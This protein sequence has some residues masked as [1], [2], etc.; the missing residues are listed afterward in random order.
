[1][2][3]LR[4][5]YLFVL[6]FI[7]GV[8][9]TETADK[10][11]VLTDARKK[12]L[13]E[14]YSKSDVLIVHQK[15]AE[16]RKK[17]MEKLKSKEAAGN[18]PLRRRLNS[19]MPEMLP[20]GNGPTVLPIHEINRDAN[21]SEFLYQADMVLTITQAEQLGNDNEGA[22]AKRQA[23]RDIFYPNTIWGRT[24]F[25]FFD[26]TAPTDVKAAFSAAAQFW[27][28]NTCIKF[29]EDSTALNRIRVFKGDGCYSYV[30]KVGGQQDLSLGK[31]CESVGTAAHELGHALGF[32]H[33]QSRVDRDSA[34][35][36][37]VDNIQP[38]FVDQF[39][40]ESPATN[41]NYG[42]PYDFGS[43]MQYG[44]T[45]ASRN[46][47]ETMVSK[48]E[49]YQET[50]GSDIVG[51]YDVSMM[52]EHYNCKVLCP[53]GSSA[54]CQNGG[55][56]N[57]NNCSICN[58]PS[59]YGGNLCNE[60]PDGCGESLKA[61]PD[62]TQLVSSIGDGTTRTNI[63]FAKCIYWIQAP[64]GTRVEV[65]IDSLQGYT[66]DGCIYGGVEIKAHADQLRTGYRFCSRSSIGKT[67]IGASNL[68]PVITFNRYGRTTSGL[69]YRYV[70][71]VA[72]SPSKPL[73]RCINYFYDCNVLA[74]FGYCQSDS[75][76]QRCRRACNDC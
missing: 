62:Y 37:I 36:I 10:F 26:P 68:L 70:T 46:G 1:M 52:N 17:W 72:P 61:G 67:L 30:G 22:R 29:V 31:G 43:I 73:V 69:S 66:I 8:G 38:S 3:I 54:Q 33:S 42:M 20:Q 50:M 75:V 5:Y 6:L 2:L 23:Y 48:D 18:Q 40:K 19:L 76:R 57:P 14:A 4:N 53:R 7:N 34:I 44:A 71:T 25:Y 55:Y 60:R 51:F 9:T 41:Y 28:S 11:S 16:L 58:C 59:G 47:R 13:L 15:L 64:T 56:P 65:R 21:L 45:S 24:V 27:Q 39:D 63:D 74:F 12:E 32:F 35:S 49:N